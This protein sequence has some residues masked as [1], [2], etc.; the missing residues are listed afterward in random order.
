ML[1]P[2][3]SNAMKALELYEEGHL[4]NAIQEAIKQVKEHPTDVRSRYLL[5]VLLCYDGQWEKADRQLQTLSTQHPDTAMTVALLRQLIRGE[6]CRVEFEESGRVPEF[7]T[8][9]S[10]QIQL[11][12]KASICIR[13]GDTQQA[14]DLLAEAEEK[15]GPLGGSLNGKEFNGFR[16]LDD[17]IA[18]VFEV[19]TSTGKYYWVPHNEVISL[20]FP[21]AKSLSDL[22]WRPVQLT[23]LNSPP[24]AVYMPSLYVGSSKSEDQAIRLGRATDWSSEAGP[25]RGSGLRMLM[26]GE[27]AVPFMEVRRLELGNSA[28]VEKP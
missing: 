22:L 5:I 7:A 4:E 3:G 12:L 28:Q 26:I 25:C 11:H 6:L 14:S 21:E 27:E 15:T 16:D 13:E 24:G 10:E 2:K 17:L 23:V 19:L 18:P 8:E 20:E 9:P 1:C